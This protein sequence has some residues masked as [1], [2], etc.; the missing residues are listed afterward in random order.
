MLLLRT[1]KLPEGRDVQYE[2]KFDGYRALAM[3]SG[4]NVNLRSRNDNDFNVRYPG[5]VKALAPMPDETVTS[6]K[7][8]DR[9]ARLR[10]TIDNHNRNIQALNKE[11]ERL[12]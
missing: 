8:L 5:I 6:P 12:R 7:Y 11:L 10:S 3:K 9:Q 1:E 2:I 4:G